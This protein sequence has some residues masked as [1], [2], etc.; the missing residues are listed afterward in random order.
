MIEALHKLFVERGE[1]RL[2]SGWR[3]LAQFWIMVFVIPILGI[4]LFSVLSLSPGLA[5][6][7]DEFI[8][9]AIGYTLSV[10][11]A[12]RWIDRRSF[13]SL[14]IEWDAAAGRDVLMGILIASV[15]LAFVFSVELGM[16]W[17]TLS[18]GAKL[19]QATWIEIAY[20]AV[21][22]VLVGWGEELVSRGYMLQNLAEGVGLKWAVF[23]SSAIFSLLHIFNPNA[24][25]ASVLGILAAG[26]FLAFGYVRTK[27]MWLPIGLHMGWN[28][29]EGPI[30]GFPVSGQE[31]ASL[32]NPEV[33]GPDLLTGGAFG[34]E[35]G[36]VVLP[37]MALGS[38][39]VFLY[40]RGRTV[41]A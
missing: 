6:L 2:R 27:K 19:S 18:A 12:R 14:G 10:Y 7:S 16:G 23:I 40:T 9:S 17:L 41:G 26:Y 25:P 33:A 13:R 4:L 39:L 3:V 11:I 1:P 38:A 34:P 37:A 36:L 22:F 35:A 30:F 5:F 29:F 20:W 15:A 21:V 8:I 24:S 28:F 32:L 31:T